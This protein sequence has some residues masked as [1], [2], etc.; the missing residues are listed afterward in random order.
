MVVYLGWG[1]RHQRPTTSLQSCMHTHPC[2]EGRRLLVVAHTSAL[3]E[4]AHDLVGM[5]GEHRDLLHACMHASRLCTSHQQHWRQRAPPICLI[6]SGLRVTRAWGLLQ[7]AQALA[8]GHADLRT[9]A[10][11]A[12]AVCTAHLC[13]HGHVTRARCACQAGGM[14][15]GQQVPAA[16]TAPSSQQQVHAWHARR[17]SA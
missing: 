10:A 6:R 8:A 2:L 9:A 12:A 1:E 4:A 3:S 17:V 13:I 15:G 5:R 11:A 14:V 7:G 16:A